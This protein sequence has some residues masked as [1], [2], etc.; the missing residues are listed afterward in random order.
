MN[1]PRAKFTMP[2]MPK[3]SVMPS[4]MMPYMA[5]M[6]APFSTWPRTSWLTGSGFDFLTTP[7]AS[8][9]ATGSR[10]ALRQRAGMYGSQ[11]LTPRALGGGSAPLPNLPPRQG[12][13]GKAG[14]RTASITG[15]LR[16]ALA[17][18]D[19][20]DLQRAALLE[21]HHVEVEDRLAALVEADLPEPV[22]GHRHQRLLDRH[23]IVDGAGLLY[24]LDQHVDVVVAGGR[25]EGGLVVREVP[26][27]EILV[28][29]DELGHLRVLLLGLLEVLGDVHHVL[30]DAVLVLQAGS[31]G[32]AHEEELRELAGLRRLPHDIVEIGVGVAREEEVRLPGRDLGEDGREVLGAG[33][34]VIE[35]VLDALLLEHGH[36]DVL[37]DLPAL[38][39]LEEHGD[40]PGA[41][42]PE[43]VVHHQLAEAVGTGVPVPGPHQE[44]VAGRPD[45]VVD[46][47]GAAPHEDLAVP[48]GRVGPD[49]QE[50]IG[51]ERPEDVLGAVHLDEALELDGGLLGLAAGVEGDELD[52]VR[53]AADLE[54]AGLVDLVDGERGALGRH[55]AVDRVGARLGFDLAEHHDV[56]RHRRPADEHEHHEKQHRTPHTGLLSPLMVPM[57]VDGASDG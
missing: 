50:D 1:S 8:S 16:Q 26:L 38:V 56:L 55:P 10:R 22:V 31:E 52:L 24:R 2:V 9:R 13:A 37:Q 15:F 7:A 4:A 20:G 12:C 47:R 43:Q 11:S 29:L 41:G 57:G 34:E 53:L 42:G 46:A 14:A 5:P 3:V 35:P 19:V 48:V 6:M 49:G 40:L 18:V 45:V 44:F 51:Q 32:T 33:I 36:V 25:A 30:L 54:A 23:R 39:V 21:P 27:V 28:G 17:R